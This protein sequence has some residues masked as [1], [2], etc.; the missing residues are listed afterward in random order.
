MR[1]ALCLGALGV[2]LSAQAATVTLHGPLYRGERLLTNVESEFQAEVRDSK[3]FL[4]LTPPLEVTIGDG[5]TVQLEAIVVKGSA[6]AEL[7]PILALADDQV[8]L[9]AT[10]RPFD[11]AQEFQHPFQVKELFLEDVDLSEASG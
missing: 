3:V 1:I 11:E 9:R 5:P 4:E 2:S 6:A 10:A 7:A 8:F